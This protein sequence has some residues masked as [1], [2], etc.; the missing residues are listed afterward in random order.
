ME[1]LG[2]FE[3]DLAFYGNF[4][5]KAAT[6]GDLRAA[7]R[8]LQ[9]AKT[10]G[11]DVDGPLYGCLCLAAERSGD[12]EKAAMYGEKAAAMGAELDQALLLKLLLEARRMSCRPLGTWSIVESID[13][14]RFACLEG[15]GAEAPGACGSLL[16][17]V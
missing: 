8:W 5:E 14:Y 3:P 1:R 17:A 7:E 9:N 12:L 2:G 13:V 11:V 4:I 16:L 15:S 10:A 6:R